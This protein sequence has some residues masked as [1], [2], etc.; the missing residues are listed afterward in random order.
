MRRIARGCRRTVAHAGRLAAALLLV[1]VAACTD[2][3]TL[4]DAVVVAAGNAHSPTVA[5]DDAGTHAFIAWV[6][7]NGTYDVMLARSTNAGEFSAPVRVNSIPG[8]AAPHAQAPAQVAVGPDGTVY[9]VWQNNTVVEGREFPASDLRFARSTD[10]GRTFEPTI[11]VN[12][13]AGGQPTS[14]T[15]HN[16]A[17]AQDGTVYVSWIDGRARA[18]SGTANVD[19]GGHAGHGL[20]AAAGA[21][22]GPQ[23]RVARSTDGGRSFEPSVV[24]ADGACPCCRTALAVAGGN[25]YVAW[26]DVADGSIRDVVVARSNDGGRT[27][28]APRVVHADGWRIDGC[29]HAGP[30]L[31]ATTDGRIHVAWYTGAPD[32]AGIH[33]ATA[34]SALSFGPPAALLAGAWVPPSLVAL[35]A[36]GTDV[37]AAWDDRRADVPVLR[38]GDPLAAVA[39][40]QVDGQAPALAA[41]GTRRIVAWLRNDTIFASNGADE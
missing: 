29:P 10:G 39:A 8:D 14:H 30:A 35:T 40:V 25:P 12:D 18:E 31:A 32:H 27:W 16:I 15:F 37:I 9:V 13:D 4:D 7:G 17:V 28:S 11:F 2:S 41:G 21:S 20:A 38:V 36:I 33:Y 19:E 24:V 3:R 1:A 6:A 5:V 23:I 26:R 22:D 34:D